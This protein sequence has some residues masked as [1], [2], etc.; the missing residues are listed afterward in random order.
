VVA[1]VQNLLEAGESIETVRQKT[2]LS[3]KRASAL[4][5]TIQGQAQMGRVA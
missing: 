1:R 3:F 5:D 2:G 4:I